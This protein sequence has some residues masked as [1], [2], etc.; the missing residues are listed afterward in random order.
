LGEHIAFAH[1]AEELLKAKQPPAQ[2]NRIIAKAVLTGAESVAASNKRQ[3]CDRV[4]RSRDQRNKSGRD[5]TILGERR[6]LHEKITGQ[7]ART[8]LVGQIC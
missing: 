5:E 4:P 3:L 7:S 6:N 1:D 8:E 2:Q